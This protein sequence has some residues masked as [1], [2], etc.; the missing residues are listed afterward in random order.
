M[1]ESDNTNVF[2]RKMNKEKHFCF[3]L[4][5]LSYLKLLF[6]GRAILLTLDGK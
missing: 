6:F 4:L 5:S 2:A 1:C 3:G